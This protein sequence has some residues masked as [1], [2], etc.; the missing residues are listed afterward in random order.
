MKNNLLLSIIVLIVSASCTRIST[1]EIGTGLIPPIDGINT[2][3]TTIDVITQNMALDSIRVSK[4]Q[5]FAL[6]S[7][8]N[9]P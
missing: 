4:Y 3:D 8:S 1:T 2:I 5:E 7:I 9:D 6:G